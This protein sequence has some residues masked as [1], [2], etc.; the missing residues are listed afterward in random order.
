[1][2]ICKG[3]EGKTAFLIRYGHLEYKVMPFGLSS[4]SAS[5]QGFI[6]KIIAEMLDIFVIVY[7]HDILTYTDKT[8]PINAVQWVVNQLR[9]Y[10]LYANLNKCYFYQ[11]KVKLISY[12]VSLEGV[13]IEDK[14]IKAVYDWLKPQSVRD[15]QAFLGFAYFYQ[16]FIQS[17][18]QIVAPLISMLR[19]MSGLATN[20]FLF[21]KNGVNKVGGSKIIINPSSKE[22]G[23]EFFT[24]RT[25]LAFAK[26]K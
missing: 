10:F 15:I 2:R 18:S 7:L 23:T 1:M 4:I 14:K 21:T 6:N 19:A 17:F 13:S 25:Q 11:D 12:M 16:Q 24:S 8:D 9:K 3:D 26:L 5:F 22:F 20:E